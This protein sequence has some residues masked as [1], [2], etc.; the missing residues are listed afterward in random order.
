MESSPTH[1]L[2]SSVFGRPMS[3]TDTASRSLPIDPSSGKMEEMTLLIKDLE[4][5]ISQR[6]KT[7]K[8]L[9][10]TVET[11]KEEA[12]NSR[13]AS[14]DALLLTPVDG[15]ID[16]MVSKRTFHFTLHSFSYVLIVF[17][18]MR[19]PCSINWRRKRT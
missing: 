8:S 5:L 12:T 18:R 4:K 19:K 10:A 11:L 6:D 14:D 13:T 2:S 3:S 9:E 15:A 7:I 17:R 1:S 16:D